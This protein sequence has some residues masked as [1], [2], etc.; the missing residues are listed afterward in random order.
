M[1]GRNV[2]QAPWP[3]TASTSSRTPWHSTIRLYPFTVARSTPSISI[4]AAMRRSH[5]LTAW[6]AQQV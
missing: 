5:S 1:E 3:R 4:P 2:D 6:D